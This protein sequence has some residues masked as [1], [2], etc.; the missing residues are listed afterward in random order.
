[1]LL[2]SPRLQVVELQD[3]SVGS[4]QGVVR[5][6]RPIGHARP[7]RRADRRVFDDLRTMPEQT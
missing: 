7:A 3:S 2:H 6:R 4:E 5:L 1:M